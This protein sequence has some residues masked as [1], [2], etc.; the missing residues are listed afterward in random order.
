VAFQAER[1]AAA[2][3][4]GARGRCR[5]YL[6]HEPRRCTD[7]TAVD[8]RIEK[9]SCTMDV[10]VAAVVWRGTGGGL[11]MD[12]GGLYKEGRMEGGAILTRAGKTGLN[13]EKRKRAKK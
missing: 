12:C 2:L 6:S 13:S 1:A 7:L 10:M 3:L 8:T 11:R 4:S 9:D 5:W